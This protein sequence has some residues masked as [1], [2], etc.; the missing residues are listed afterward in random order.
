MTTTTLGSVLRK[1]RKTAGYTLREA[2][3]ITE[4][5]KSHLSGIEND[6]SVP[7]LLVAARLSKLYG[8]GL[9][10]LVAA[11][12]TSATTSEETQPE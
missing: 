10:D 7:G 8:V 2:S 5:S 3:L 12:N 9:D 11:A 1:V 6:N 4:M